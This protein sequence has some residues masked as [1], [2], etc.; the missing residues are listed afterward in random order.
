MRLFPTRHLTKSAVFEVCAVILVAAGGV[1]L[2]TSGLDAVPFWVDEAESSINALTI[3]QH[4][5]PTDSYLGL[6]IFE[7]TLIEPWPGNPEYEFRDVSYSERGVAVY[8]GWFPLYSIAASFAISGVKPDEVDPAPSV[9][10]DLNERKRLT[11]AARMPAVLFGAGFLIVVFVGAK[12]MYGRDAA[13]TALILGSIHPNAIQ[14]SRQ[15]RYYS[16]QLLWTTACCVLVWAMVRRGRWRHFVM[17]GAAFVLLFHTHLLS[18]ITA[19]MVLGFATPLILKA[20][21]QALAKMA[22]FGTIVAVGTLPWL[23]LTGF[24]THQGVIPR[25]W[26]L[27]RLPSDLVEFPPFQPATMVL[28]TIF[29]AAAAVALLT[30]QRVPS[31]AKK[32]LTDAAPSLTL[33]LAWTV[34]GYA[35][36]LALMPAASFDTSRLNLSYWG[37]A[38]IGASV[39]CAAIAR[40]LGTRL[41][42]LVA[43]AIGLALFALTGH[44]LHVQSPGQRVGEE[45]AGH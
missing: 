19:V 33:V 11:R 39:V 4:G 27:L 28:G 43:P 35:A 21:E 24:L 30:R 13:W 45:H 18:F 3:L 5:Y 10:H 14:Q 8:H 12:M 25:A 17:A 41:T 1:A 37:P 26:P 2:R 15:A 16:A 29:A 36:F 34:C 32:P 7:N 42:Q 38:L 20:H 23:I 44:S 31:R 6:P 40:M 9:K 22:V